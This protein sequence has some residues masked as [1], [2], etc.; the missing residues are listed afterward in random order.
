[1]K[2]R[3]RQEAVEAGELS[4]VEEEANKR[5]AKKVKNVKKESN[6]LDHSGLF[7][8][9]TRY[10]S[11]AIFGKTNKRDGSVGTGKKTF[12]E[13]NLQ[14]KEPTG[15]TLGKKKKKPKPS[16]KSFKSKARYKRRK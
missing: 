11:K 7:N 5:A 3:E 8:E 10:A 14:W 4:I 15:G 9:E 2:K 6:K 1:M 13:K 16:N 12:K